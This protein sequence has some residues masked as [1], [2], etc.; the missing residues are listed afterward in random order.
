MQPLI[1]LLRWKE[2]EHE[3]IHQQKH[4]SAEELAY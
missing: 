3:N 4:M 1:S 2:I